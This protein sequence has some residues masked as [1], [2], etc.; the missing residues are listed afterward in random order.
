M[1]DAKLKELLV[2][3][4]AIFE[5]IDNIGKEL[6]EGTDRKLEYYYNILDVLSGCYIYLSPNTKRL[7]ADKKNDEL[8]CYMALKLDATQNETKFVSAPA[9]RE[10]SL[11]VKNLRKARNIFQGYLAATEMSINTAKR[12]IKA[13]DNENR[14]Q[15]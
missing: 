15:V 12:H 2:E 7:E 13:Y 11:T 6:F 14:V 3:A 5:K 9:E 4:K 8:D 1:K 10:S